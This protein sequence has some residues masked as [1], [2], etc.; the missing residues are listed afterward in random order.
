M[1]EK[2]NPK[3]KELE[4]KRNV[5][6]RQL[7]VVFRKMSDFQGLEMTDEDANLWSLVTNHS[8][9]QKSIM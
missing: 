5:L 4:R 2:Y 3:L 1:S 6:I 8:A 9:C 7:W